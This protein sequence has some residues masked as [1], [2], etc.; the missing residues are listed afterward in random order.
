MSTTETRAPGRGRPAGQRGGRRAGLYAY[1][2][3]RR[4]PAPTDKAVG[5]CFLAVLLI[6]VGVGAGLT[7]A[8]EEPQEIPRFSPASRGNRAAV[9]ERSEVVDLAAEVFGADLAGYVAA[10]VACESSNRPAVDTNWPYVG[11]LQIDPALH[12]HRLERIVGYALT[13]G[14]TRALLTD[15]LLNLLVGADVQRE[16]GWTAWPACRWAR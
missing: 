15:P 6:L 9:L 10:I 4:W 14:Q 16:Q 5:A 12:R 11:L 7:R 3:H 13:L 2:T 1:G 8:S